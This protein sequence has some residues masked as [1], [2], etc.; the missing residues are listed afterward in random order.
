MKKGDYYEKAFRGTSNHQDTERAEGIWLAY[1]GHMPS[2]GYQRF[3][4]IMNLYRRFA[5][6]LVVEISI[7]DHLVVQ[8]LDFLVDFHGKS[9]SIISDNEPEL[10]NKVVKEC[11]AKGIIWH[12]TRVLASLPITT[13]WRAWMVRFVMNVLTGMNFGIFEDAKSCIEAWRQFYNYKHMHS[14]LRYKTPAQFMEDVVRSN[15]K[16][17]RCMQQIDNHHM[18]SYYG[19]KCV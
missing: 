9:E 19:I 10:T 6:M 5:L 3:L 12:H 16:M 1:C 14:S 11:A 13:M 15:K 18:Y 17:H 2:L 7:T 4:N 8:V